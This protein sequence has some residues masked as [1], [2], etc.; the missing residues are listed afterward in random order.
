MILP[1]LQVILATLLIGYAALWRRQQMKRRSRSWHAI[2]NQLHGNDWGIEDITE[3][4]L[5]K[6]EVQV[7]PKDVWQRIQG[8][9]GLWAMYKN[10]PV[11][12]QLADYAAEHGEGVDLEMLEGL[13]SD[14][15]QIRVCVL[16]AL[17]QYLFSASSVGAAVNAHRAVATY[18]AMLVRLTAFIQEYSTALFPSYLD[19]VA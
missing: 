2:I 9:K 19:A 1:M 16:M 14:A 7:T 5:Y 10:S 3:R 4:F 15:F 17:G 8:C 18:S 12:V 11:L 13:R 6:G